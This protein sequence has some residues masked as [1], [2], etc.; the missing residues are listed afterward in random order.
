MTAYNTTIVNSYI[1]N[2][3]LHVNLKIVVTEAWLNKMEGI[4]V[5]GMCALRVVIILY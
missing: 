1:F 4:P 5:C 3:K 2:R